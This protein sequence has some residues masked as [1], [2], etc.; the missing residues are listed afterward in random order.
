MTG[1]AVFVR[2]TPLEWQESS[3]CRGVDTNIFF[4]HDEKD[5]CIAL[6]KEACG[7]CPAV[8]QCLNF[9]LVHNLNDGIYGGLTEKERSKYR[10]QW[11]KSRRTS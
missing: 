10:R 8:D 5:P 11:L 4:P 9:A 1:K 3:L 6:A 2:K 7:R